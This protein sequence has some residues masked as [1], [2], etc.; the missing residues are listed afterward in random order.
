M[1]N[2]FPQKIQPARLSKWLGLVGYFINGAWGRAE[3]GRS[4]LVWLSWV[5]ILVWQPLI[6]LNFQT[7]NQNC[8]VANCWKML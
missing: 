4:Y 5:N 1:A 2:F 6:R 8:I 7:S 3:S